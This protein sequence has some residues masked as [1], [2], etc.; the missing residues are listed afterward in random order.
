MPKPLLSIGMIVKN[1]IRCIERCLHCLQPLRDSIPC[2]LVIADTG[3]TDGTRTVLERFADILFDFPWCDDFS[4]AR[5]AVLDHCSGKWFFAVDADEYLDPDFSQLI[6]LLTGPDADHYIRAAIN[7][8]NYPDIEMTGGAADF[9][10]IRL[11]RREKGLRYTGRI[12]EALAPV[13]ADQCKLLPDV[14]LHHDGYAADR[15]DPRRME[16]K[17]E[18]NLELL[19]LELKRDPQNLQ[20]L[21]QCVESSLWFPAREADNVRRAMEAV[22]QKLNTKEGRDWG[23]VICRVALEAAAKLK[24]VELEEWR[25]WSLS[26]FSDSIFIR[27]DGMFVLLVHDSDQK[28]YA[29]VSKLA[30]AYLSAW[31]DYQSRNFDL[32]ELL[33]S[34][35]RHASLQSEVFVRAAGL[36]ALGRLGRHEEAAA[37]LAGEHNW[38]ALNPKDVR[39]LL[40]GSA[41]SA[42]NKDIQIAIDKAAKAL[43]SLPEKKRQS[44]KAFQTVAD[45]TFCDQGAINDPDRPWRMFRHLEG[46][47]GLAVQIMDCAQANEAEFLLSQVSKWEDFPACV[48]L[49]ALLLGAALPDGV[50]V[51]GF[52][53]RQEKITAMAQRDPDFAFHMAVRRWEPA[54]T[55]SKLQ[56][57]YD[58]TAGALQLIAPLREAG[59]RKLCQTLCNKLS[60]LAE[61]LFSQLYSPQL[62]ASPEDWGVLPGLHQFGLWLWTAE[63]AQKRGDIA[64]YVHALRCGLERMPQMKD[65]VEFLLNRAEAEEKDVPELRKLADQVRDILSKFP[66]DDPA[67]AA[68]KQSDIYRKV[69]YLIEGTPAPVFGAVTQ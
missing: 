24:M 62:L 22:K 23:P 21:A 48:L 50:C 42:G 13:R 52:G 27:L 4:A 59:E 46:D 51:L 29:S 43:L 60:D 18:R 66:P 47:L 44:W 9:L 58:L 49:H 45:Q 19:D 5:N 26:A 69:S 31:E 53:L 63:Q 15:K 8:Y 56:F 11:A 68:L 25:Q 65:M 41:W 38:A 30:K 64:G 28:D 33:H 10:A 14:K 16:R 57:Q 2:E 6:D 37:L 40:I 55:L 35:I 54:N 3:S 20:R 39:R 67:V 12:H 61:G 34:T 1:E 32:E 36:E 7:Q 17:A